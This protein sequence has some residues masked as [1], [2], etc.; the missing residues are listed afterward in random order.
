[1]VNAN[2]VRNALLLIALWVVA[3]F[4]ETISLLLI[5]R[6]D[7]F[8]L[9]Q[10]L[11]FPTYIG[12][13]IKLAF[14]AVVYFT[15]GFASYFIFQ[16]PHR[17]VWVSVLAISIALPGFFYVFDLPTNWVTWSNALVPLVMLIIGGRVAS[18]RGS[19]SSITNSKR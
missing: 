12:T 5:F 3:Y 11:G 15:L 17:L 8:Q 19:V 10:K 9:P 16:S 14:F 13:P 4:I 2:V 18:C 7:F 1:M 6:L